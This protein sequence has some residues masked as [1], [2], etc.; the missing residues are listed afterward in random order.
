MTAAC[1]H[2]TS[3]CSGRAAA[4]HRPRRGS[5][6][7]G[8]PLSDSSLAGQVRVVETAVYGA[9]RAQAHRVMC[10]LQEHG[11]ACRILSEPRP[12]H[13]WY[14]NF[15]PWPRPQCRVLVPAEQVALAQQ[16]L[17]PLQQLESRQASRIARRIR[18]RFVSMALCAV[19][20]ASFTIAAIFGPGSYV[21]GAL[22]CFGALLALL[23]GA[24]RQSPMTP[25]VPSGAC[26]HA[27]TNI[28]DHN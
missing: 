15:S 4:R 1:H 19:G 6:V 18:W 23:I 9:A 12:Y 27:G 10:M 13:Y 22:A 26:P 21:I 28:H 24:H 17:A 5:V 16:V 11:I 25:S 20:C 3:R 2:L 14:T 7:R 8:P